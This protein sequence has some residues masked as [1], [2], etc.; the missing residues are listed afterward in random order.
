LAVA[1]AAARGKLII[2]IDV[3]AADASGGG[4]LSNP[5][6]FIIMIMPKKRGARGNGTPLFY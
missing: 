2:C 5:G 6:F 4:L 1:Y 3:P